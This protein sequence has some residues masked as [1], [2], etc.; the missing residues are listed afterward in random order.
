MRNLSF[1]D[2]TSSPNGDDNIPYFT[3]DGHETQ[4]PPPQ[5][6][7][8]DQSYPAFHDIAFQQRQMG[9]P[10]ALE[11]LYN[12][13]ADF[14]V[15][16]FNVR[17]YQEFKDTAISDQQ[18]GNDSGLSYLVRFYGKILSGPVPLSE[19]LAADIVGLSREDGAD[20]RPVLQM[21]R[22]AWRNGATNMK[23]IKRL[24]DVLTVEEKAELDRSG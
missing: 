16:N 7:Q 13:W 14:L 24:G 1:Q 17:L 18:A 21:M 12:F 6:G 20:K 19:R 4:L 9:V 5:V 10:E 8:F 11:P 22:A 3:K 15:D 23:T 2:S